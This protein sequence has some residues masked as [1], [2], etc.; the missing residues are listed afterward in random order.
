MKRYH[1]KQEQKAINEPVRSF[2]VGQLVLYQDNLHKKWRKGVVL[3]VSKEGEKVYR[4]K[5]QNRPVKE[6]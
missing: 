2:E 3:V 4:I 5:A 6:K 1:V